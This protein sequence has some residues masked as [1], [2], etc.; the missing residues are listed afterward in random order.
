[1]LIY[2]WTTTAKARTTLTAN[3][4]Q[5]RSWTH[6]IE[7]VERLVR[8]TS[9]SDDPLRWRIDHPVCLVAEQQRIS[10]PMHAI[11]GRRTYLQTQAIVN[12]VADP[13]AYK[14]EST[15]PDEIFIEGPIGEFRTVLAELLTDDEDLLARARALGIATRPTPAVSRLPRP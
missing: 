1:M 10:N 5:A 14:L 2:H 7:S 8:G 15:E 12:P 4:L 6:Y 13:N 11:N 3:R 9:W